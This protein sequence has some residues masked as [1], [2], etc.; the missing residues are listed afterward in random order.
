MCSLN[1]LKR[2]TCS[3]TCSSATQ[4]ILLISIYSS[5]SWAVIHLSWNTAACA[6]MKVQ[7]IA[8]NRRCVCEF[9]VCVINLRFTGQ[10]RAFCTHSQ[11]PN[12]T[13]TS[14]THIRMLWFIANTL[15]IGPL[16]TASDVFT[17]WVYSMLWANISHWSY[18]PPEETCKRESGPIKSV[19]LCF[20]FPDFM[21]MDFILMVFEL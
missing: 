21:D 11:Q 2:A 12:Q 13:H 4:I 9:R 16:V 20:P 8:G 3:L 15:S 19:W 18:C 7:A 6:E 10:N 17:M 14:R 5:V 1:V